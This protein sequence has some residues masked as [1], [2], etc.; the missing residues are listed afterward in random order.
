MAVLE[1]TPYKSASKKDADLEKELAV[2]LH[3]FC[4]KE[5]RFSSY[6]PVVMLCYLLLSQDEITN[7]IRII[8]GCKYGVSAQEVRKNLIGIDD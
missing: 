8:E 4:K 2:F 5:I 7:L 6:P 3:S 1:K